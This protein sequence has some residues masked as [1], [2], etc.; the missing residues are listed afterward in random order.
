[1]AQKK[2]LYKKNINQK[3]K[4]IIS[5]YKL[6]KLKFNKNKQKRSSSHTVIIRNNHNT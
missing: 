5:N 4:E 6:K 1:M 3:I 2:E